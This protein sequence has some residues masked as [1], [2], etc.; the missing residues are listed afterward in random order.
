[1]MRARKHNK[2]QRKDANPQLHRSRTGKQTGKS[3]TQAKESLSGWDGFACDQ[4]ATESN[5]LSPAALLS[6]EQHSSREICRP[7]SATRRASLIARVQCRKSRLDH[8]AWTAFDA[9]RHFTYRPVRTD[10]RKLS[11]RTAVKPPE[12]HP[13]NVA[14]IVCAAKPARH[15]NCRRRC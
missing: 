9:R 5:I 7:R 3:P 15:R 12:D 4:T 13:A 8:A 11:D 2:N 10:C 6:N 1:M 14:P